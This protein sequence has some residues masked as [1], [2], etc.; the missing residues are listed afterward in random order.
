MSVNAILGRLDLRDRDDVST[1]VDEFYRRVFADGL[2]GPVFV[3]IARVDLAAHLP[4]MCDFWETAL[5]RTGSYH[6]N[7]M[8]R[9]YELDQKASLTT[10]HF[11]RWLQ[12]WCATVDRL[13]SGP[14]AD[15]AKLMATRIARGMALRILGAVD[16]MPAPGA[17]THANDAPAGAT[18]RGPARPRALERTT[19]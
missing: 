9:H 18:E 2:L 10:A 14:V 12:I 8:L 5:F 4:K 19:R 13:Y 6:G 7:V 11:D 1:L 17:A 3:D 16:Y 15:A